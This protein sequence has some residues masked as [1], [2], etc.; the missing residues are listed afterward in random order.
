MLATDSAAAAVELAT[1]QAAIQLTI[2][3]AVDSCS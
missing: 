1:I 2:Q 3:L